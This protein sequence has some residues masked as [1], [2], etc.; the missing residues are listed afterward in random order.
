MDSSVELQKLSFITSGD[1][2]LGNNSPCFLV[3]YVNYRFHIGFVYPH[4]KAF[5][6][7]MTWTS[8]LHPGLHVLSFSFDESPP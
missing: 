3:V 5:V 4:S 8:S 2:L 7:T 1:Q 6:A